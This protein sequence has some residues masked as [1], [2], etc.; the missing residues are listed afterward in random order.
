MNLINENFSEHLSNYFLTE[1]VSLFLYSLIRCSRPQSILEMGAGYSTPFISRAIEDVKNEN[2]TFF[3]NFHLV[4]EKYYGKEYNPN[5]DVIENFYTE[6]YYNEV[7]LNLKRLDLEKNVNFIDQNLVY[8]LENTIKKY[9]LIWMD[10]GNG[11]EYM[12]FFKLFLRILNDGG[13]VI[14]HNTMHNLTGK[15]FVSELKLMTKFDN[16]IELINIVEPHKTEQSSFTIVKKT[17]DYPTHR[18]Y[19]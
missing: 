7:V 19:A 15:L 18:V 17:I 14:I 11:E 8:F 2:L 12:Y 3:E 13:Y 10:L 9:D 1:N 4:N 16:S 6:E 5:F